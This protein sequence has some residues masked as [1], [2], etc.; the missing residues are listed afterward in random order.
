METIGSKRSC[1][2]TWRMPNNDVMMMI[3]VT[4]Y[5]SISVYTAKIMLI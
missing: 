2:L 4:E 5:N 1:A 3:I